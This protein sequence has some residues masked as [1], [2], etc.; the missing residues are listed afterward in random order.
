M[1]SRKTIEDMWGLLAIEYPEYGKQMTTPQVRAQIDLYTRLLADIPDEVLIAAALKHTRTCKWFPK[2]SE[3]CEVAFSMMEVGIKTAEEAWNEVTKEMRRV[4]YYGN[5]DFT[6][7]EI[8]DAVNTFGWENMC[9]AE[10]HSVLRAHFYRTYETYLKR[11][12]E[13]RRMLPEIRNLIKGLLASK[14]PQKVITGG[15]T[16]AAG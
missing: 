15:L 6:C 1:A 12:R 7:Q 10:D 9:S 2:V 5:P 4:G 14:G 11:S 16:K 3:L 13:E 8:Y